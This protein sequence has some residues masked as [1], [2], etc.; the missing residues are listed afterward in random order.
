MHKLMSRLVLI[1]AM[2]VCLLLLQSVSHAGAVSEEAR[3]HMARGQAAVEMAK[4]PVELEDAIKEFQEA[5]R[6]APNWP[7][8]YYNLALLQEKTGK[9]KEAVASLKQYLRL[10]PNAPD[11][12]KVKERIYKLEYKAERENILTI[13]DIV[14]ILVSFGKEETWEIVKKGN[15]FTDA[16]TFITRVGNDRIKVPKS[17][18]YVDSNQY[19]VCEAESESF[20]IIKIEGPLVKF[21]IVWSHCGCPICHRA[22]RWMCT[23]EYEVEVVSKTYVKARCM[24]HLRVEGYEPESEYRKR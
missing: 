24:T 11:A 16:Y 6:L 1:A 17:I 10:A 19:R 12:A 21:A 7:D 15:G 9:L 18:Y 2:I 8:P 3:R 23:A 22:D 14:D 20:N 4:S 13:A 5:S